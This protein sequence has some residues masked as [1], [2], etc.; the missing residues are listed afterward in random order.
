LHHRYSGGVQW[1]PIAGVALG[2]A[3]ILVSAK[4]AG[5]LAAR[6]KQPPVLGELLVGMLLGNLGLPVMQGLADDAT[7]DMLSRL[8]VLILLF[9]VGLESTVR[10]VMNVGVAAARVAVLG[11]LATFGV[12]F[13]AA[14]VFA[15]GTD[16]QGQVF[17]AAAIT[18]TSVGIT[19]RVFKDLGRSRDIEARTILGASVLDDILGLVA[20]ALVTG[21]I[22]GGS[23]GG[24]GALGVALL[25][26]KTLA[27]L[28]I[29]LVVG[30]RVT[31][32]LFAGA[33]RLRTGGALLA[34]GLA[35]CFVLSWAAG[36]MG[37][38]PLVGAFAAGLILEDLHS[39]R[40]VARGER[41]LSELIEPISFFLVPIF[42]VRM[43]LRADVRVFLDPGTLVL[44]LTL[45][46]AAVLGKLACAAGAPAGANRFAV[47]F[48]MVPRGEVSLVFA[49][50]GVS[51][52]HGSGML[53][54]GRAYSALVSVVILTT[55][56]SPALLKW[57][58][59]RARQ[60]A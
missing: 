4:L 15:R 10:D 50:L 6:L 14:R 17:L 60:L 58:F 57:S 41:S 56:L 13:A 42:F 16:V 22:Q 47:G 43:G 31:P 40:F 24:P 12:G 36:A 5:D 26:G 45:T 9:E 25:V 52:P 7:I 19:A 28:V 51:T 34:A 38:A 18:A 48:G 27:F 33:A 30:I 53:L 1:D 35:F 11:S 32:R 44:A 59:G 54:D 21:W 8:G 49:S 20:L 55:V 37:L 29:A 23:S 3:A 46:L 39:A 2:L